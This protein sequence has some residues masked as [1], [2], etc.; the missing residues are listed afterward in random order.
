MHSWLGP[1]AGSGIVKAADLFPRLFWLYDTHYSGRLNSERLDNDPSGARYGCFLPDLTGLARRLPAPTSQGSPTT[2]AKK[3]QYLEFKTLL[4]LIRRVIKPQHVQESLYMKLAETVTF[5]GSGLDRAAALRGTARATPHEQSRTIVLWRGKILA[6]V[7]ASQSVSRVL[8]SEAALEKGRWIF[9]GIDGDD[10]LFAV[11]IS[12]W[13]PKDYKKPDPA[14]FFDQS[15]QDHPAFSPA[16][17]C[18]LR[19]IMGVL[20][21]RDAE[22]AATAKAL[23]HWHNSAKYCSRCGAILAMTLSGWQRDCDGCG[24]KHFP[25]TDPVVIMLITHGD[26]VLL[27]RSPQWPERMYSLLAGFI[28]PGETLEAAVRREVLEEAGI[29]V[30]AV[31]YLAS[32]PWSFP[33][34]L[35]FGCRGE[36]LTKKIILD[37]NEIEDAVWMSKSEVAHAFDDKEAAIKPARFGSIAQFL[38]KHWLAD[39]LD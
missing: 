6:D 33:H 15:V 1:Q 11:D 7:S 12:H 23:I 24:A 8:F 39:Q 21:P 13:Q 18:E 36:A 31:S 4:I 20:S 35:M 28:E 22:L 27:G 30:G 16:R 3:P 38:L 9:L 29:E 25:R 17:F 19:E 26:E 32:Q 10:P 2:F 34:S 5:G 14:V 37:E